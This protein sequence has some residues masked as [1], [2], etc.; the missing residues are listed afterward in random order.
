MGFIK[1]CLLFVLT[2]F[3]IL[4]CA[5]N[6]YHFPLK[7]TAQTTNTALASQPFN[8]DIRFP[9]GAFTN[10]GRGPGIIDVTR[11]PYNAKG[12]GKTDDTGAIQ[13]A[14][15][16]AYHTGIL[17]LPQG[18]YLVSKT[19]E[20]IQSNSEPRARLIIHGQG[21]NKTTIKL[22]D[23]APY[24][25]DPSKPQPVIQTRGWKQRS[26]FEANKAFYNS[27][28]YLTVDTGKRNPGAVGINWMVS[29]EGTLRHIHIQ[30]SDRKGIAGLQMLRDPGPGL[31]YDVTIDGFDYGI[32]LGGNRNQSITAEQI[33]I[34]HQ[35]QA[36]IR[37]RSNTLSIHNLQSINTVPA[38]LHDVSEDAHT[39]IVDAT[40]TGGNIENSAIDNAKSAK[41]FIR[42]LN[43][44]GYGK[45]INNHPDSPSPDVTD[46][47]GSIH[48]NQWVS[49]N[50]LS[51]FDESSEQSLGLEIK[52]AP[53]YHSNDF[54][55]WANVLDF[56]DDGT[57][58]D[59]IR[60]Q[61]AIDSGAKTIYFPRKS[62]R[63]KTKVII[64]GNVQRV[65]GFK[66]VLVGKGFRIDDVSGDFFII[67]QFVN[68]PSII[69]IN[70]PKTTVIRDLHGFVYNSSQGVGDIFI[71]NVAGKNAGING[72]V[73]IQYGA[74]AWIR[75]LNPVTAAPEAKSIRLLN[76]NST[77]W[78]LGLATE[79][80][81]NI[82][83]TENGGK[84][85]LLGVQVYS[86]FK[87]QGNDIAYII[88]NAEMSIISSEISFSDAFHYNIWVKE[89]REGQTRIL[90]RNSSGMLRRGRG[91]I[92]PLFIGIDSHSD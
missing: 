30:S 24:F 68:S 57:G 16:D 36:G 32:D 84:T 58:N 45:A 29:N 11:P 56:S 37:N 6:S 77:V 65:L 27:L 43:V 35:K 31:L 61:K 89:T 62:Y 33:L 1:R 63:L 13:Q 91:K 10:N 40:L 81:G 51:L 67:E 20:W 49:H 55:T 5:G 73:H 48:I 9:V 25:Q 72:G 60:I 4:Q 21:R 90:R 17:Y 41:V 88:D 54:T 39:I 71:E 66:S 69:E 79:H 85:E 76:N 83:T 15:H 7:D 78:L 23:H 3:A 75:Q 8:E 82:V 59:S 53:E 92:I 46:G 42:N 22:V 12:D 87:A 80:N 18:T 14:I 26:N 2:V 70:T 52:I 64:R 44:Q 86:N 28:Y 47:V 74:R 38:V 34:R 19:L 50:A